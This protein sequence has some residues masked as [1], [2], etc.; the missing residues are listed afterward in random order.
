MAPSYG[1]GLQAMAKSGAYSDHLTTALL[2][3]VDDLNA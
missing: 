3:V 2:Q 1:M